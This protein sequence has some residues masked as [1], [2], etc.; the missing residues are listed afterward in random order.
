MSEHQIRFQA[1]KRR[2][3]KKKRFFK[4]KKQQQASV[5]LFLFLLHCNYFRPLEWPP[6]IFKNCLQSPPP[7][8][9][10]AVLHLSGKSAIIG[11]FVK[12]LLVY[13]KGPTATNVEAG[14]GGGWREG[15]INHSLTDE[16]RG[17]KQ[18]LIHRERKIN[19]EEGNYREQMRTA[20]PTHAGCLPWLGLYG[21][22]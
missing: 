1:L 20:F 14:G 11:S 6:L 22:V 3:G 7:L 10:A 13:A 18:K 12:G 8:Q 17:R 16:Y 15:I 4:K 5:P 2:A 9:P 19:Q 21:P